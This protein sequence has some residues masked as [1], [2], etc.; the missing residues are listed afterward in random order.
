MSSRG[1]KKRERQRNRLQGALIELQERHEELEKELALRVSNKTTIY[2]D[3]NHWVHMRDV[4][5]KRPSAKPEYQEI[6]ALLEN[7]VERDAVVCP[8]SS[9]MF[10]ELMLQSDTV[11]RGETARLMDRL[12]R[13]V[14]LQFI[15]TLAR[16]EWQH[17][18]WGIIRNSAP[19]TTFPIWTTAGF[20]AGQAESL[21]DVETWEKTGEKALRAW[22]EMMWEIGFEGVQKLPGYLPYPDE[23]GQLFVQ[24]MNDP[25][26]RCKASKR[27]FD[28]LRSDQKLGFLTSMT[29]DFLKESLPHTDSVPSEVFSSFVEE[30]DPRIIPPFQILA[31]LNAAVLRSNR[32]VFENDSQDFNHAASGIP[33]CDAFF[34]DGKMARFLISEPLEFNR[35]YSTTILSKASEI[36][37]YLKSIPT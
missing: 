36:V 23:F 17:N 30:H 7:L 25:E 10:D 27:T 5:L 3:T 20:W 21:K 33:Y 28:Q 9:Q 15:L 19:E 16:R 14:C 2:L 1:K 29:D 12:S 32:R 6:L 34:C 26:A 4:I 31:G 22:F 13:K 18:V 35:V 37:D 11:T 24:Q 8:V